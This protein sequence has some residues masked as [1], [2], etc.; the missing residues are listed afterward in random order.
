ME[1][2]ENLEANYRATEEQISLQPAS[3]ASAIVDNRGPARGW[4]RLVVAGFWLMGLV[5]TG[6]A[7]WQL[8]GE[9]DTPIGPR[10]TTLFAGLIY[11]ITA[12][13]LTH[14]GRRM[15][16]IAWTCLSVALAGP[17]IWGLIGL[18]V[19]RIDLA[20]S[21][22]ADF[23]AN[24]WFLSL[25]FPVVGLVWLWWSNPRRIVEIAEGL[26]RISWYGK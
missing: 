22:W 18:G 21:P 5:I 25:I 26:E 3:P 16:V 1:T 12:V 6:I 20:W 8:F 7:V 11:V 15:R 9:N 4:G 10:L 14:N 24:T 19:P 23:G 13:G 2:G 17:L